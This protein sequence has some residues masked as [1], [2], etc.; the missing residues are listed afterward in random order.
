MEQHTYTFG[1]K[2]RKLRIE[3]EYTLDY[4]SKLSKISVTTL[5]RIELNNFKNIPTKQLEKLAP[6]LG[7]S[8]EYLLL[9]TEFLKH[10]S[11]ELINFVINPESAHYIELAYLDWKKNKLLNKNL[12]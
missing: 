9:D 11:P 2:V 1:D 5:N 7:T 3:K 12:S 10:L 8:V 6:I 4:L